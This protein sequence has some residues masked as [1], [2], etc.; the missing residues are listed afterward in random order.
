MIFFIVRVLSTV[1]S[2]VSPFFFCSLDGLGVV[3]LVLKVVLL[4]MILV[5]RGGGSF[6]C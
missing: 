5:S 2:G 1:W 3:L 4:V 6:S